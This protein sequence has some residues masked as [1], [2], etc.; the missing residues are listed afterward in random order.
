MEGELVERQWENSNNNFD[1]IFGAVLIL[2]EISTLEMWPDYM[3]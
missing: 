2:F 1:N 3:Y